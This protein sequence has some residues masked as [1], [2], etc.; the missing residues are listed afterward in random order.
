[1]LTGSR[2]LRTIARMAQKLYPFRFRD[3]VTGKWVR[4]RYRATPD[5]IARRY[6][7]ARID[8][9]GVA[10]A[11]V[12]TGFDP[13]RAAATRAPH[14][15]HAEPPLELETAVADALERALVVIFLRRYVTWCA[16]RRR[17]AAM[18]G[19]AHLLRTLSSAGPSPG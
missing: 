6:G 8:G 16:R 1:M 15:A 9:D 12:S 13:F 2:A 10:P 4:A 5:D 17:Y 3:P 19:A 14:D 7:E 18:N 11:N